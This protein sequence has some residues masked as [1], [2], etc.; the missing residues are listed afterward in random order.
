MASLTLTAARSEPLGILGVKGLRE[1]KTGLQLSEAVRFGSLRSVADTSAIPT[2]IS[3]NMQSKWTCPRCQRTLLANLS[4]I[5]AH[6]AADC[7]SSGDVGHEQLGEGAAA[8]DIGGL[9]DGQHRP[10][11]M[12][13][14]GG[15]SEGGPAQMPPP[16]KKR[17]RIGSSVKKGGS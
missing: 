12:A 14:G 8:M 1:A 13:D 3:D 6:L 7:D 16:K 11:G 2:T 10:A 4:G 17:G 9:G 5:R 15:G